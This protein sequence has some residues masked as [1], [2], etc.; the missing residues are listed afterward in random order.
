LAFFANTAESC[1]SNVKHD[2][3]IF[4]RRFLASI[5]IGTA[6]CGYAYADDCAPELGMHFQRFMRAA[7]L[8][9][10]GSQKGFQELRESRTAFT[11]TLKSMQRQ[12]PGAEERSASA[13]YS[14][15]HLLD[16]IAANWIRFDLA[17]E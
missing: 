11:E 3:G 4:L 8:L 15:V 14:S 17:A 7:T 2:S 5:L 6:T 10:H 9:E 16:S 12:A 1:M 13:S